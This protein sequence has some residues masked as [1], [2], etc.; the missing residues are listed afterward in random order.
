MT[1]ER[2]A[3]IDQREEPKTFLPSPDT[4]VQGD[5]MVWLQ[6]AG[7]DSLGSAL[8]T[9]YTVRK[10]HYPLYYQLRTEGELSHED[11]VEMVWLLHE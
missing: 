6:L 8:V 4:A 3:L 11:A 5:H 7:F 9:K 10:D 1:T 2:R